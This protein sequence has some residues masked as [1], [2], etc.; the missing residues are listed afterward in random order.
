MM[1]LTYIGAIVTLG[2]C[3]LLSGCMPEQQAVNVTKNEKSNQLIDSGN[4]KYTSQDRLVQ[5][6]AE[7][8]SL[9]LQ[10]KGN[11]VYSPVA[12]YLMLSLLAEGAVGATQT[13]LFEGLYQTPT[14]RKTLHQF[15]EALL[16]KYLGSGDIKMANALWLDKPVKL[17]S[18]FKEL[19]ETYYYG[20]IKRV[21]FTDN[22]EKAAK[23]IS[24][25]AKANVGETT[26]DTS[27]IEPGFALVLLNSSHLELEW[28]HPF[29]EKLTKEEPFNGNELKT[30][31][32]Q[33]QFASFP[34]GI[35]DDYLATSLPLKNGNRLQL[36]LPN[37]GVDVRSLIDTKEKMLSLFWIV[38]DKKS[39]MTLSI[40]KFNVVSNL[41]LQPN[42]DKMGFGRAFSKKEAGFS[43]LSS[44]VSLYLGRALQTNQLSFAENQV[45]GAGY[46]QV[47]MPIV[48]EEATIAPVPP[49]VEEPVLEFKLNRPFIYLISDQDGV[50]ILQGIVD[51]PTLTK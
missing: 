51:N 22:P 10:S 24:N 34:Y 44:N 33:Q 37:E 47:M 8:S 41:D 7:S 15:N 3:L 12:P 5:F 17:T 26:Y 45:D 6:A 18:P 9:M 16:G 48:P 30:A 14:S 36:I 32:M 50:P 19:A 46:T 31:M 25:W 1:K 2:S 13:E 29:D 35:G 42:L 11:Q 39:K 38:E 40:P 20:D 49:V 23:T 21:P 4:E 27:L 43:R 28:Q